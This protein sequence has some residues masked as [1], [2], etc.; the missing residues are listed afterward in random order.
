MFGMSFDR[1]FPAAF[2]KVNDRTHTPIYATVATM[3]GG[4][5]V[6]LLTLT[7]YGFLMSAANT[8][9]WYA[10]AYLIVAFTAIVLP[11]KR[12]DI[13]EKG[14]KTKL[15]GVPVMSLVGAFGA[16]GMFWIL[17]LSTVG[18]SLLAWNVSVLWMLIG[19]LVFMFFLAKNER[20]GIKLT[21]IYGEVPPP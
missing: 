18:I 14:T 6:A 17:A 1:M 2:G 11:Y 19:V 13:W 3:I 15:F 10:F 9:F 12:P 7:S 8:S 20:H 16:I 4:L 5:I 21:A